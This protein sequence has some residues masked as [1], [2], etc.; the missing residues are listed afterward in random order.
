MILLFFLVSILANRF[1][2]E[3]SVY[4][5]RQDFCFVLIWFGSQ[6]V[7]VCVFVSDQAHSHLT[8]LWI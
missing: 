2:Y 8:F 3:N 5:S 7:R 4:L 1:R 6:C